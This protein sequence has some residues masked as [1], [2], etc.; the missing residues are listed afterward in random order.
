MTTADSLREACKRA[1]Y[2]VLM[3][4]EVTSEVCAAILNIDER[5]LRW[6]REQGDGPAWHTQRPGG[7]G[8]VLYT[9]AAIAAFVE[10]RQATANNGSGRQAVPGARHPKEG[11]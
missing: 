1:R 7:R 2:H 5:T 11:A 3:T 10:G 8:R 6:W 9:L 4:D